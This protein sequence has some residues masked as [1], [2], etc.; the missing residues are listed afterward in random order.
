MP[1]F[2]EPRA[3]IFLRVSGATMLFWLFSRIHGTEPV[4]NGDLKKMAI[5]SFFGVT[6]N[7]ILF[8]EGL[9]LSTPINAS[10]IMVAVPIAVMAFSSLFRTENLTVT[11][12][13]GIILGTM[14]ATMLILTKGS[15]VLSS[16][17]ALGNL[18]IVINATSYALYLVLIKPMMLKYKALT[19][20]KWV[21]LFGSFT[22]LPITAP[23]AYHAQWQLI[24]WNIWLSVMYVILFTTVMAYFLNNFSLK[25]ISPATNSAFIYLQPFFTT[26]ISILL[27]KDFLQAHM[28]LPALLIFSGVFLVSFLPVSTKR[29]LKQL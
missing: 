2:L 3:I 11:K 1:D 25:R 22:A 4:E 15:F 5:A 17:T 21:F 24:P 23:A 26:V 13:F 12:F 19:V 10:I 28:I 16:S 14:G 6:I 8:F 29:N 18:L 7:Q 27:G 20:M 9:N